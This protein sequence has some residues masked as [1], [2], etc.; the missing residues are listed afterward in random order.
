MPALP[1]SHPDKWVYDLHTQLKHR[2]LTQY[3]HPWILILGNRSRSLA[4]VDGFAGRGRY[5]NGEL[6]LPLL[7]LDAMQRHQATRNPA[8]QFTCHFVEQDK[9]NFANLKLEVESHPAVQS[10]QIHCRLYNSS[11]AEA[12]GAIITEIRRQ[13]QPSFFFVDPFGYDDPIMDVLRQ[14]L[15]L[16]RSEVLI[17]LMFNFA[18]RAVSIDDNPALAEV[19]DRLFG[20]TEWRRFA[21]MSGIER[22]RAFVD[23][24]RQQLRVNGANFAIRFRMGD[25]EI[26]RTLYYLVHGTKAERGSRIMKDVMIALAS[27]GELGYAGARRHQYRPLFNLNISQLPN[28]LLQRFAGRNVSFDGVIAQTLE[29]EET[30]TCRE[31][32]YRDALKMLESARRVQIRR[33]TSVRSGLKCQDQIIF[34]PM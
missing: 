8:Q 7:V 23:L 22:E 2:I 13:G 17:N 5:A 24:Y 21:G 33:I 19:L 3:L 15:A 14:V 18:N 31:K 34:P 32:D 6:G 27:P 11:F 4:Y 12:S 28:Y 10:G 30:A 9:A 16:P 20:T 29:D 25:D 1:D 26:N